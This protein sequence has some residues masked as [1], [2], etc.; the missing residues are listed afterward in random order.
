MKHALY[1]LWYAKGTDWAEVT[2][3]SEKISLS[4]CQVVVIWKHQLCRQ[5]VS[6]SVENSAK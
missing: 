6:Q 3:S 2:S 4:S 1:V 5:L